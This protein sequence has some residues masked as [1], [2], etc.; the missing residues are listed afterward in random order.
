MGGRILHIVWSG[1]GIRLIPLPQGSFGTI[2]ADPPWSFTYSTRQSESGNNGWRGSTDRHYKT[3]KLSELREM[4]IGDIAAA[5]SVLWLWSVNALL[6]DAMSLMSAWGF[7]YKNCLTWAKTNKAGTGP[8]FGMGY[9]LR[10][11]SEHLLVGVRGRPKPLRRNVPTWFS[12]PTQRHSEKPDEAYALVESL[13][14]GPYVD[15]FAR[16][17]RPGWSVWGDE[18]GG[19]EIE[20][21]SDGRQ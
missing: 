13:S 7:D 8:A 11:A 5:D 1:M 4:P 18:A 14:P 3:M 12:A 20:G 10:G 15:L 2:V 21:N 19:N 9:W 16:R 17:P 6:D